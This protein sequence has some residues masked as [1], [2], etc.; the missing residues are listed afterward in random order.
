MSTRSMVHGF[1]RGVIDSFRGIRSIVLLAFYQRKP[2][3][4]NVT[5]ARNKSKSM[6]DPQKPV[7][8][9]MQC[10]ALNGGIFLLSLLVWGSVLLPVLERISPSPVAWRYLYPVLNSLFSVMWIIPLFLIS[11]IINFLWFQ[12]SKLPETGKSRTHGRVPRVHPFGK[13]IADVLLSVFIQFLFLVQSLIVTSLPIVWVGN[14]LG[15]LH[16]SFLY[17]LYAF[18]YKW[19]SL[20]WALDRRL[21]EIELHWPYFVGF[22]LPMSVLTSFHDSYFVSGC[23]FSVFF[24]ILIISA[25]ESVTEP[26]GGCPMKLFY[27][28]VKLTDM[29]LHSVAWYREQRL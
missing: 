13:L 2:D 14:L 17:S 9:I 4:V 20:G 16:R 8:K 10:C 23:L 1:F 28:V 11:R 24:P 15:L 22:G 7:R 19:F 3:G 27:P 18:E 29:L 21:E 6:P 26:F 25:H 12:A 5:K